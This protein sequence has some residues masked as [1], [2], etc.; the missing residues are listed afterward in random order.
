MQSEFAEVNGVRLHYMTAGQGRLI[1]S[2]TAFLNSGTSGRSSWRIFRATTR[3]WRP[4][5]A[6]TISRPSLLMSLSMS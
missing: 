5:C 1:M 2:C 3:R 4:I 6:A